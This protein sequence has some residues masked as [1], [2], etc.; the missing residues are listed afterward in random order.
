MHTCHATQQ[1][2]PS[3]KALHVVAHTSSVHAPALCLQLLL[4]LVSHATCMY[5]A[6]NMPPPTFV[7]EL[8][9]DPR[10]HNA[11]L[12]VLRTVLQALHMAGFCSMHAMFVACTAP[13][14]AGLTMCTAQLN[15]GNVQVVC[16]VSPHQHLRG[17]C[18]HTLLRHWTAQ[19]MFTGCLQCNENTPAGCAACS[20]VCVLPGA[21]FHQADRRLRT[22]E[23]C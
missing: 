2:V 22:C 7:A 15:G 3:I 20:A 6:L 9:I 19:R 13:P 14:A 16:C 5:A 1:Y 11:L 4:L 8:W 17:Y 10:I 18:I 12:M 21:V 23:C